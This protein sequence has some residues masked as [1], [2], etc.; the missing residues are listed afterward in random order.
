MQPFQAR[1]VDEKREL[2]S[3]ID[4]LSDFIDMSGQFEKLDEG[5]QSRLRIQKACMKAYS[6]ALGERIAHFK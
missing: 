2:D 5:E 1:V 3:K 6:T 4:K